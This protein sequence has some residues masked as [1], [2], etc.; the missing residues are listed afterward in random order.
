MATRPKN[1]IT[2]DKAV[3]RIGSD[4]IPEEWTISIPDS[5]YGLDMLIEVVQDNKTT[6]QLF[7]VQSKGTTDSYRDGTISYSMSIE[8]I[9]D[10]S[11]ISLPVLFVYYSQIENRFWGRWM[12]SVYEQLD[13]RQKQ[14]ET[15]SLVF[16]SENEIDVH[17]LRSIGQK[18]Q[19]TI[20]NQVSLRFAPFS[21]CFKRLDFQLIYLINRYVSGDITLD[22]HLC[23][24]SFDIEMDGTP[25]QG[26]IS[27]SNNKESV[28][29]PI[30][31]PKIDFLYYPNLTI[32]DVPQ[33]VL[34]I[35]F[36]VAFYSS[37]LS[38]ESRHYVLSHLTDSAFNLIP[39]DAW[40]S[41]ALRIS[42]DDFR[43]ITSLLDYA[44][45]GG[46][47]DII[48]FILTRAFSLASSN[49]EF[50]GLYQL[51]LKRCFS[52][53]SD[54]ETKGSLCYNL[55]NSTRSEDLYQA[56]FWY[57]RASKF[58][59]DYLNRSYWWEEVAGILYMTSHYFLAESFYE[60]AKKIGGE[61]IR[62]DIDMLIS[63]CLVCQGRLGEASRFEANYLE[64]SPK[65]PSLGVIRYTVT[66]RMIDTKVDCFDPI[67]W[68]NKGID[69][70]HND[71]HCEALDCFLFSW[72]LEDSDFESLSNALM[73]A[74]NIGDFSILAI[75]AGALRDLA[76]DESF[77]NILNTILSEDNRR[78]YGNE[79]LIEAFNILL[80]SPPSQLSE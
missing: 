39:S 79:A 5:D 2:G 76:P 7:F 72:R 62:E 3:R 47:Y 68:F 19:P 1:H 9:C 12:N 25:S 36:V 14:Q 4:L 69:Y 6:G 22:N 26:I 38:L 57:R 43:G 31:F 64:T 56:F 29:V 66:K 58:E 50:K 41:F 73:E 59:P 77:R 28:T 63:D 71:K 49:E 34:D 70:S 30:S 8:R 24:Q 65:N 42:D 54:D 37:S 45:K 74:F 46:C 15:L 23:I 11:R 61:N 33:C 48:P 80:L 40:I 75:I 78:A 18:I 16:T 53:I 51:I 20:T 27:F 52:G 32:Q 10:Y 67:Y 17:Y 55:G 35:L 44:V 21:E 13:S 60:K